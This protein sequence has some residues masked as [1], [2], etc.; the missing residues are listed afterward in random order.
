MCCCGGLVGCEATVG[1]RGFGYSFRVLHIFFVGLGWFASGL[2]FHS[3]IPFVFLISL[4]GLGG[5]A[6]FSLL[7]RIV[8]CCSF[9]W[10][11]W[12][13]GCTVRENGSVCVMRGMSR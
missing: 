5:Y 9:P 3:F 12:V 2:V 11:D 1:R 7:E 4:F 6:D 8:F 10:G 13:M